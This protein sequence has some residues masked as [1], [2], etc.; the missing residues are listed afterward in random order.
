MSSIR[1]VSANAA[2]GVTPKARSSFTFSADQKSSVQSVLSKFDSKNLSVTDAKT[3]TA[4]FKKLGVQ[5]GRELEQAMAAS[6]FD[7]KQ[8]GDLAFGRSQPP[9]GGTSAGSSKAI[10]NRSISELKSLLASNSLSSADSG[11]SDE[12]VSLAIDSF[13]KS[14]FSRS[15]DLRAAS[16]SNQEPQGGRPPSGP[17][18]GNPPANLLASDSY[19]D[20]MGIETYFKDLI[21]SFTLESNSARS[22]VSAS[23]GA[24]NVIQSASYLLN[25]SGIDASSEN[26]Q[27]FLNLLQKNL[28][29]SLEGK[30][31]FVEHWA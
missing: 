20:S 23:A 17:K 21:A 3:I 4:E 2:L 30:G 31:N 14:V 10:V 6:G 26:L 12:V 13:L 5:P 25:I 28:A 24:S 1:S 19:Q 11:K 29:T 16:I 7:A 9:G 15:A 8:V 22:G 18:S 27:S